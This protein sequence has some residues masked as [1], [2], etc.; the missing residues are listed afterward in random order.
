M[1]NFQLSVLCLVI[2]LVL[3]FAN[4]R[5]YRRFRKL[6]LMPLVLTPVLL[7]LM[8]VF[9]HISYQNYM[10][11][12]H[13]LLWLLGPATIAFAV[14][15][16]DNLAIIKRHWMSLSAGVVT[17]TV[18][19]VTSSVWLARLFTLSDEIQRSLAVRSI[20]T[21]FALAAAKSLGGQPELVALFVVVTGVFGM[22][23]GDVLFLRLAIREGMAKG[24]GFGAASHGAGTARSYELGPQ[25]GVVASL[26]MML[27]G[28]VMVLVA[29]LVGWIMF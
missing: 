7:V 28:V 13:W 10:G 18:V 22:A 6:P 20:T 15:V 9:G 23:I 12:A 1:S 19:A 8:L 17:A 29:P 24:A 27:S 21:P 25:E 26:V 11:E 2:T 3:Y 14:P 5:L 16:Y 4:K